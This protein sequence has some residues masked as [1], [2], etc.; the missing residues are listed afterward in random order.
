MK[1]MTKENYTTPV[2]VKHESL[3]DL[4][5]RGSYACNDNE[6]GNQNLNLW[7]RWTQ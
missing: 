4:T 5:A 1:N 6:G 7:Y 2:L 3:R